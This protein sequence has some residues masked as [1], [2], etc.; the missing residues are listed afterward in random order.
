M[1]KVQSLP[2]IDRVTSSREQLLEF[3]VI[4]VLFGITAG[5]YSFLFN[6]ANVLSHSIGY[7]LYASERVLEGSVPYRDFHT[8]YPPATFY[9]NALVFKWLGVSLHSALLGVMIFKVLTVLA[10]YLSGRE[11]MPRVWAL[12]VALLSVLWLRPN[13]PFKSVPMHYGALFLALAL[14]LLLRHENNKQLGSI[15]FAGASLGFVALFKHNIGAYALA[16]SWA[17]IIFEN[18]D[19]RR[20][21][22]Q[23]QNSKDLEATVQEPGSGRH[24][25]YRS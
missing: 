18:I 17:W 1:V 25:I 15:C 2:S 22:R 14:Y 9:L 24:R 21:K 19:V 6:R 23:S 20:G 16:G 12:A 5:V 13:G 7:N 8:L 3:L 4:L 11:I 10:I